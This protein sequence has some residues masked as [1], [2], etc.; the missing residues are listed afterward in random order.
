DADSAGTL[1]AMD[2]PPDR[3]DSLPFVKIARLFGAA[4]VTTPT[5]IAE[6][7]PQGFLLLSDLGES[8]Y[9]QALDAGADAHPM[10]LDALDSLGRIRA[11]TRAGVLPP[12]DHA[13][14]LTELRLFPDWYLARHLRV[15]L[16]A[17]DKTALER[18]F[19][20]LVASALALP[21]VFVHRDYH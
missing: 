13:R 17:D 12:Y 16:T 2:A 10:Y 6:A 4:G 3:E 20:G 19:E 8:T 18:I 11:A 15:E 7:L 14:L 1:I 9:L 21:A 5:I